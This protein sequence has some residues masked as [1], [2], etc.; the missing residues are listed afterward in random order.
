MQWF[1]Q[2]VNHIGAGTKVIVDIENII[3]LHGFK[4]YRN[5]ACPIEFENLIAG[6]SIAGHTTGTIGEVDLQI[7]VDSEVIIFRS[8]RY[9]LLSG[10]LVGGWLLIK[11]FG[12]GSVIWDDPDSVNTCCAMDLTALTVATNG[13]FCDVPT[14][15]DLFYGYVFH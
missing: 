14:G 9:D 11:V 15:G 7:L 10:S 4:G 6:E 1:K 2:V 3:D 8:L 13:A 12:F 5:L